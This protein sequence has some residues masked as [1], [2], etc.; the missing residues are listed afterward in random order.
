MAEFRQKKAIF[1]K[2]VSFH[3]EV[4]S[5]KDQVLIKSIHDRKV[6]IYWISRYLRST[7]LLLSNYINTCVKI[8]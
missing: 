7:F 6:L 5:N 8:S 2:A 1:I 3:T 4:E